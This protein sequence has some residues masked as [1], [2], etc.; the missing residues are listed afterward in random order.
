M[1]RHHPRDRNKGLNYSC[2]LQL[3]NW[4]GCEDSSILCTDGQRINPTIPKKLVISTKIQGTHLLTS[5]AILR[6]S[7][8]KYIVDV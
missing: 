4:Q 7:F 6:N 5:L 8:C 3:S 1:E 2:V